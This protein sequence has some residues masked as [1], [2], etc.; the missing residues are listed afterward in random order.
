MNVLLERPNT[1]TSAV[2]TDRLRVASSR[3]PVMAPELMVMVALLP[4]VAATG[5]LLSWRDEEAAGYAERLGWD[6]AG[7]RYPP[8]SGVVV[9]SDGQQER[10]A[11]TGGAAGTGG[12]VPDVS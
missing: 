3:K 2:S 4:C 11:V 6:G 9:A 5:R 10:D 12:G 7:G 8:R 1:V